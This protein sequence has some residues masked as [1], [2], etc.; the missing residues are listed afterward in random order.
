MALWAGTLLSVTAP[1]IGKSVCTHHLTEDAMRFFAVGFWGIRW[2]SGLLDQTASL[3][4]RRISAQCSF[5]Y[6]LMLWPCWWRVLQHDSDLVKGKSQ[7]VG[8][9]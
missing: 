8:A 1:F 7:Q 3:D 4:A 6:V 9:E 2:D 5:G